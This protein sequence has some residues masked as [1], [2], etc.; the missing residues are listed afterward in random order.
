M[1]GKTHYRRLARQLRAEHQA[2]APP[3]D[4]LTPLLARPEYREA[5]T[6]ALFLPLPGEP[7]TAAV[8][9]HCHDT[10]K[11]PAVP[12]WD[13]A[14]RAYSFCALLP[15]A[16]LTASEFGVLQPAEKI[17]VATDSVDLFLVP[18]LLFD[19]QGNRL[20]HGKG[21]YD[22]LL[23]NRRADA[24]AWGI[25]Y[26]WQIIAEPLPAESHDVRMNAVISPL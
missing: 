19:K 24:P 18:G 5:K 15:G 14:K 11:T 7:T 20:G 10:G 8:C 12:A 2:D 23:A 21:F 22:R 9:A 13:A 17:P 25:A 1:D 3:P 4:L 16:T 26:E 6:V